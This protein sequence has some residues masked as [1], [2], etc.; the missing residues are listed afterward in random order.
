MERLHSSGSEL[1][2]SL[3]LLWY[4]IKWGCTS[5]SQQERTGAR[6]APCLLH[7]NGGGV[8]GKKEEWG[9]QGIGADSQT[10]CVHVC[11]ERIRWACQTMDRR[12]ISILHGPPLDLHPHYTHTHTKSQPHSASLQKYLEPI[13][14]NDSQCLM[15]FM[16][17]EVGYSF[18]GRKGVGEVSRRS[19]L[20]YR[21]PSARFS[22]PI[23]QQGARSALGPVVVWFITGKVGRS[24]DCL[25]P[26]LFPS[27]REVHI[28]TTGWSAQWITNQRI[29]NVSSFLLH[30]SNKLRKTFKL[31]KCVLNASYYSSYQM[32]FSPLLWCCV[33]A[34]NT[35][36]YFLNVKL[37]Q[38]QNYK[39][40]R[41]KFNKWESL[42]VCFG[43]WCHVRQPWRISRIT[44][45]FV[46]WLLY[47]Q[48]HQWVFHMLSI[49]RVCGTKPVLEITLMQGDSA[50]K[51]LS[52]SILCVPVY[53]PVLGW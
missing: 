52:S 31:D 42:N 4:I 34:A 32:F 36:L 41:V 10:R 48:L 12:D 25:K 44:F 16:E 20:L 11:V 30:K 45:G 49:H 2:L 53:Q 38:L 21:F 28:Y 1:S 14:T 37:Q 17:D 43:C 33:S 40:N 15:H 9:W 50:N 46:Q 22:W 18:G 47:V 23:F 19:T 24:P 27:C 8:G 39:C 51:C 29:E 6:G 13:C 5:P 26:R 3:C 35:K 7:R